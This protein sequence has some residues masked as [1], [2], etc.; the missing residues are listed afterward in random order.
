MTRSAIPVKLFFRFIPRVWWVILLMGFVLKFAVPEDVPIPDLVINA[1]L[2]LIFLRLSTIVHE[3]GHLAAA[4]FVGGTPRRM[5]L[6]IGHEVHRTEVA[7]VKVLL[8]AVARGGQ[9]I[10]TFDDERYIKWKYAVYMAG[11]VG[12]N[13]LVAFIGLLVFGFEP[14]FLSGHYGVDVAGA[15][16]LANAVSVINLVPFHTSFYGPKM[17]T[18]GLAM[19]MLLFESKN[20]YKDLA[21]KNQLFD[22][23]ENIEERE[24]DKAYEFFRTYHERFPDELSPLF[25]LSV[26]HLRKGEMDEANNLLTDLEKK[27]DSKELKHYK[28]YLYNNLAWLYLIR[29]DIALAHHYAVLALKAMPRNSTIRGTYGSVL[30]EKG[31][32]LEGMKWL[33]KNMDLEHPNSIT[34]ASSMYLMV[35]LHLQGDFAARDLHLNFVQNNIAKLE[36][37]ERMLF[38]RNIQKLK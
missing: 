19:L 36:Q 33:Y 10:A 18:D 11:G 12:L 7:G 9:A 21:F 15:L 23:Y 20:K 13:L 38:E 2:L 26:I 22:A 25:S 16:I 3:C 14:A 24:Y 17:P 29:N 34:L 37:D 28:G 5:I 1:V 4:K 35:A 31:K 6:G 32:V 30:V 8:N 27:I